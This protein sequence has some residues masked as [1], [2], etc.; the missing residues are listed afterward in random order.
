MLVVEP[1]NDCFIDDALEGLQRE[2][3]PMRPMRRNKRDRDMWFD[4]VVV[5][6][7]VRAVAL[8]EDAAVFLSAQRCNVQAMRGGELEL[9][10][11]QH[12]IGRGG[13]HG[14]AMV[15]RQMPAD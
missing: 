4:F 12:T 1:L 6:V 14:E 13:G 7:T 5:A 3:R 10:R 15:G 11:D 8:A 9:L 2:C